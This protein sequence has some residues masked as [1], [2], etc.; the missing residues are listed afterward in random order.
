MRNP[1]THKFLA[2]A[3]PTSVLFVGGCLALVA[4]LAQTYD[5]VK[6]WAQKLFDQW[7]PIVSAPWFL[8]AGVVVICAYIWALVWTGQERKSASG[9]R[10]WG[11]GLEHL[12]VSSGASSPLETAFF[13]L[14]RN[15][16]PVDQIIAAKERSNE[17]A[18]ERRLSGEQW[19]SL[20]NAVRYLASGSQW[21][22][23]QNHADPHFPTKLG[24]QLRDALA[25]GD[26]A[27]RGREYHVLRGGITDPP[28]HPLRPIPSDFWERATIEA[29]WPLQGRVQ[30]VASRGVESVVRKSDHDGMHDVC[31]SRRELEAL[32]PVTSHNKARQ[33]DLITQGRNIA[34]GY[35]HEKPEGGFRAY[36]E[37]QRAYSDIR[38]H[39]SQGYLAKLNAQRMLYAKADGARLE[40]L[41]QWFLDEIDRL[42]REW[43]LT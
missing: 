18:I 9:V 17:A 8:I 41:V 13:P 34:F 36:L 30:S 43:N 5:G 29:Y 37:G 32:W 23:E 33:R 14:P 16:G 20:D 24:I 1:A 11:H 31:F 2:W 39:L 28:L 25:C 40:T 26:L 35:T 21:G 12:K 10:L 6:N 3:G 7:W 19:V 42:E 15:K 22:A 4:S 38:P 27:A